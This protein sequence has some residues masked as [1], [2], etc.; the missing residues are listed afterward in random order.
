MYREDL[1]QLL[2]FFQKVGATV[3]ISDKHN[4]YDSLDDMK[5]HVG[6]EISELDIRAENPRVHF[7]L[8]QSE[9]VKG[10]PSTMLFYYNELRTE[11]VSDEAENLFYKISDFLA[12]HKAARFRPYFMAAA[13]G[14]LVG[15]IVFVAI[16][17][18]TFKNGQVSLGF[19]I[20]LFVATVLIGASMLGSNQIR[21]ETRVNSPAFWQKNKE[22][23][24][25]HAITS[26]ISGIIGYLLGRILK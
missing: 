12:K 18:Q 20:C 19:L 11:E 14:A 10:S 4:R 22:A 15:S 7:L 16:D 25:M 6:V 17:Y 8:N 24:A 13:I 23:L 21:L 2:A 26:V 5:A 9:V 3:T 1:D